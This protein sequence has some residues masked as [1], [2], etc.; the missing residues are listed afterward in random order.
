[1]IFTNV[2]KT[3]PAINPEELKG[4]GLNSRTGVDPEIKII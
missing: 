3:V 2:L 1:M 4:Q